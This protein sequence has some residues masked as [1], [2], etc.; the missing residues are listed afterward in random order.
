V[1]NSHPLGRHWHNSRAENNTAILERVVARCGESKYVICRLQ[2]EWYGREL[3]LAAMK[4]VW[5][6]IE[7]NGGFWTR[8]KL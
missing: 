2:L 4:E 5:G 3:L 7:P 1:I 6:F 8:W